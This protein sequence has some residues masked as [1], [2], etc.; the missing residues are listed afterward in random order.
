MMR[1]EAVKRAGREQATASQLVTV[2]RRMAFIY[3]QPNTHTHMQP[4]A[5][6]QVWLFLL[7]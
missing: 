7:S 6:T 5:K 1:G 3:P 4:T 2:V